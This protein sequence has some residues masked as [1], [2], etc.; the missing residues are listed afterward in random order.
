MV[1]AGPRTCGGAEAALEVPILRTCCRHRIIP[2]LEDEWPRARVVTLQKSF[3]LLA[4]FRDIAPL[5][6]YRGP[7]RWRTTGCWSPTWNALSVAWFNR[8]ARLTRACWRWRSIQLSTTK[9]S[10]NRPSFAPDWGEFSGQCARRPC[11]KCL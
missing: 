4:D 7:R 11:R 3:D 2:A 1:L 9:L 8:S 6:A 10:M 5:L